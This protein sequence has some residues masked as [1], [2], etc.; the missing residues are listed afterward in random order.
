MAATAGANS[1]GR[2]VLTAIVGVV[3][4]AVVI[5]GLLWFQETRR[6]PAERLPPIFRST[7]GLPELFQLRKERPRESEWTARLALWFYEAGHYLTALEYLDEA[8]AAGAPPGRLLPYRAIILGNLDRHAES[9]AVLREIIRTDPN[10]LAPR[11]QLATELLAEGRQDEALRT[12][13]AIP[14]DP[15]GLPLPLDPDGPAGGAARLAATYETLGATREAERLALT[16]LSVAPGHAD[17]HLVYGRQ[18]LRRGQARA[19]GEHFADAL[20]RRPDDYPIQLL[21]ARSLLAGAKEA[22]PGELRALLEHIAGR[23][24][25]PSQTN[26]E[27]A[28]IYFREGKWKRAAELFRAASGGTLTTPE[29]LGRASTAFAKAGDQENALYTRGLYFEMLQR[30][31]LAIREY[32]KLS[33]LHNCCQNGYIHQARALGKQGRHREAIAKL[34]AAAQ[35]ETPLPKLLMEFARAY[36]LTKDP[37]RAATMWNRFIAADPANADLGYASLGAIADTAGRLDEAERHYRKAVELQP[38]ADLYRIRLANHLVERRASAGKLSEAIGHLEKAV[39]L[40]PY[41]AAAY[42]H[43]GVAYRYQDRLRDAVWSLRHAVD[44]DPGDGRPYQPL[45]ECLIAMGRR[46]DGAATLAL[47]RRYRQFHQAW[48]TLRAR[49]RRNPRDVD[50]L[51]RIA[52]FYERVGDHSAALDSYVK[53][54]ELTPD[55]RQTSRRVDE[56][57][58]R[59]GRSEGISDIPLTPA[60]RS[61]G[62]NPS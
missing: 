27:L 30:P 56:L 26:Y 34:E 24:G 50:A 14:V 5:G 12:L 55:D 17:A 10:A 29:T 4:A 37:A 51:R 25:A 38:E 3:G 7:L 44:L 39:S 60:S 28:T 31:D 40:A 42:F 62:T 53:V 47:F 22:R 32:E 48:E 6:P 21:R 52:A 57:Y 15:K 54:L 23:P 49:I 46:E 33:K 11:L 18:L 19:A 59:I 2:L 9:A 8:I 43:L 36:D 61:T 41:N 35:K 20:A 16:A 58:R 1:R 45:G 13:R